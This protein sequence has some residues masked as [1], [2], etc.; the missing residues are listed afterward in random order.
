MKE[1]SSIIF[2]PKRK[3]TNTTMLQTIKEKAIK[4]QGRILKQNS[5]FKNFLENLIKILI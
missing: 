3:T 5:P 4:L 2:F 1:T